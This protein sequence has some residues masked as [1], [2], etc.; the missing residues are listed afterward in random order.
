MLFQLAVSHPE[1]PDVPPSPPESQSD[2]RSLR[3]H[4]DA[5]PAPAHP[6]QTGGWNYVDAT[7]AVTPAL[8][9]ANLL[10]QIKYYEDLHDSPHPP[11]A[12][13]DDQTRN[14]HHES[15]AG[16]RPQHSKTTQPRVVA[17]GDL[18]GDITAFWEALILAGAIDEVSHRWIGKDMIIVQVGDQ[19]DRGSSERALFEFL[20]DLQTQAK[21]AGGAV[22]CLLGNHEWLNVFGGFNYVS[23]PQGFL[24]FDDTIQDTTPPH[25]VNS[26]PTTS[27][28]ARAFMPGGAVARILASR[29]I[30]AIESQTLFVHAG[31]S[32]AH[33]SIGLDA[34]NDLVSQYLNGNFSLH[35]EV[36][37]LVM[38]ADSPVWLRRWGSQVP[39][40]D[41]AALAGMLDSIGVSRMVIGHTLQMSGITSACDNMLWRI[42]TGLSAFYQPQLDDPGSIQVLQILGDD[43]SVLSN[44]MV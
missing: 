21:A 26:S 24:D 42:D 41:C 8:R 31:I 40:S 23:Y 17:I 38:D 4:H 27:G 22:V 11:P 13:L 18:H 32:E 19:V 16:A 30:F 35:D 3:Q 44:H 20:A 7:E 10:Q 1:M 43:V 33:V 6:Q 39:E 36:F 14:T 25:Q 5:A 34:M 9:H 28:R 15:A 29:P 12:H 2:R 37:S